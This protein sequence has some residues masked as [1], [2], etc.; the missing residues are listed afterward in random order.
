M[1]RCSGQRAARRQSTIKGEIALRISRG[2]GGRLGLG[3]AAGRARRR[4]E[5]REE[6]EEGQSG[7]E[8]ISEGEASSSTLRRRSTQGEHLRGM[9]ERGGLK[10][11]GVM[12]AGWVN[13]RDVVDTP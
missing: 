11:G 1:L 12:C 13:K 9:G 4:A 8:E 5:R 7:R 2:D 10:G 6:A 3:V